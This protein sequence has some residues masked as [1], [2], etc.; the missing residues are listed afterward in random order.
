MGGIIGAVLVSA[1]ITRGVLARAKRLRG[2]RL[3][4]MLPNDLLEDA[5]R[6]HGH[7][8]PFLVLGL[9]AGLLATEYLG[10][11][12]FELKA[13]VET[14]SHPPQSCFIDGVQ[15]ASGCTTGKCNLTVEVGSN[16]SAEFIR[17]ERGIRLA[18][19]D[20]ILRALDNLSSEEQVEKMS[21]E[22]IRKPDDEV[23]VIRRD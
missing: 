13:R 18:V 22:L 7:L 15:F 12:Y 2:R 23:F 19:Q 8:G 3:W 4:L 21:S 5:V 17:G 6:F 10:K 11:S 9:R 1:P 16:V 14:A 20:N